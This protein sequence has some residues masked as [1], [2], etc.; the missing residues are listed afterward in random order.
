MHQKRFNY[1]ETALTSSAGLPQADQQAILGCAA[2]VDAVINQCVGGEMHLNVGERELEILRSRQTNPV[3]LN[4][5]NMGL[6]EIAR[7]RDQVRERKLMR[8]LWKRKATT[9]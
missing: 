1:Q 5:V 6:M 3:A 7:W 8:A 4:I 9:S 2:A